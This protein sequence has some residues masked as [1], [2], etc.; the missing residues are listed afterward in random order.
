MIT[1]MMSQYLQIKDKYKDCIV[2]FRL[3]DFYEMFFEDAK[4]ASKEL[5]L[6]LTKRECGLEEKAPMCGI[7]H[8]SSPTYINKLINKGFKVAICEQI[9][10]SNASKGIVNRDVVKI[11]TPGTYFNENSNDNF[12]NVFLGSVFYDIYNEV[13]GVTFGDITTGEVYSTSLDDASLLIDELMKFSPKELIVNE[14]FNFDK[15]LSPFQNEFLIT[16]KDIAFFTN[17]KLPKNVDKEKNLYEHQINSIGGFYNYIYETQRMSL[18]NIKQVEFYNINDFLLIDKNTKKNLELITNTYDNSKKSSLFWVLNNTNTSMGSRLL[19]RWIEKPLLKIGKIIRRQNCVEELIEKYNLH[20]NLKN[21]LSEITDIDR[22]ISKISLMTINP[23]ELLSLKK[24]LKLLPEI[25]RILIQF[26]ASLFKDIYNHFDVLDDIYDLIEDSISDDAGIAIKDGSIIKENYNIE[27]DELKNIKFNSKECLLNIENKEKETTGIR[28][29]KIGYNRI[30]GYYIE[31]SKSNYDLV[32]ENRYIRKQTLANSERYITEE[33]KDLEEKIISAEEKL[34]DLEY[35]VF[36]DIRDKVEKNVVRMKEVS[37]HIATIDCLFSLAVVAIKNKY[38]KPKIT[39]DGVIDIHEARHPVVEKLLN[40]FNYVPNDVYLNNFE[41]QLHIIT[42][43]NMAGKSTFMRQVALIVIMTQIGSFVPAKKAQISICDKIFTRIGA[44]DDLS[45]GRS[46]FMVEMKEVAHIM[47]NFTQNSLII[48]DEVG[49]GTSTYDG[50]SI[51]YAII[52]YLTSISKVR[53]KT[54]FA[55]HYHEL[56]R[57]EEIIPNVKNYSVSAKK[58]GDNLIFSRKVSKG[59]VDDS[60]G[61]EVA[62]LAGINQYIID[63]A[64]NVMKTLEKQIDCKDIIEYQ[65]SQEEI[66]VEEIDETQEFIK[67]IKS[68]DILNITPMDALTKLNEL[69][70]NSKNL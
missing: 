53:P 10:E 49:R 37:R 28:S 8:V 16:T 39:E 52:E 62:K 46:T 66:I 7:P 17:A 4:I 63:V 23:K 2:F 1:P 56:T 12:F 57:I 48:L 14:D 42:G 47:D 64:K 34:N 18:S 15:L 36:L 59:A 43:P 24:C 41:E 22:L 50:L 40:K 35:K 13:F 51:A 61:I 20:A 55:T 9:E 5:E 67:K 31:V 21:L 32:P 44:S 60:Y 26:N 25:K 65:N 58:I 70:E 11:I 19:K 38:V 69:V 45:T 33:L 68:I 6:V 54:L 29:L 27:I 3:G 30:F